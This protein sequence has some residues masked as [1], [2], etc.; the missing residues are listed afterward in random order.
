MI[1]SPEILSTT[2]QR[3]AC[4]HLVIAKDRIQ[5]E[6]GPGVQEL[7]GAVAAQGITPSGPWFTH[8][9]KIDDSGW[10][11]EICLPVE[12]TV[13]AAGRVKPGELPAATVARTEYHGN[14]D[15]LPAAWAALDAWVAANGHK[16]EAG[17]VEVY[18]SGPES[19]D[20]PSDWRTQL[21]R[22]LVR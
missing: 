22:L 19:S 7:F 5:H 4:I 13:K 14:Y 6:M 17:M 2:P 18:L 9:F 12:T 20:D 8:H 1:D 11:F 15:G 10:D 21:N 16:A 3:V